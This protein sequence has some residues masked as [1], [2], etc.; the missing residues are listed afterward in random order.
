MKH[1]STIYFLVLMVNL[2]AQ[3]QDKNLL[4]RVDV[5]QLKE[6]PYSEW[7]T[8]N[9]EAYRPNA[10]FVEALKKTK[11]N[12]YTIQIFFGSWCGDSQRELPKMMRLLKEI[13]FPE[14]NVT[15]IGVDNSTDVYK[16]SPQ[17][18]ETG[19][20]IF[21][22]PTF[23]VYDGKTE[24]SR[25]VEYLAESMERDLL[26]I[27]SRQPYR[28]NYA[29]YPQVIDW[30]KEGLLLDENINARGLAMKIKESVSGDSELNACGYVLM[31]QGNVKEAVTVFKINA[32]LFPQSVNCW[33]SLGEGYAKAGLRDKAIQAYEYV[34]ELD[35]KNENARAQLL[36][37]KE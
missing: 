18:Y 15:L 16:Q 21:R 35:P 8:K 11:P 12:K 20:H 30:K 6:A 25:I 9:F 7:Y 13:G 28:S 3:H 4:D 26:K 24:V 5:A 17:R 33:D 19:K 23:I 36:K 1:Y 14:S 2:H 32:N 22:V 31:A 34:L 37:L 29:A 27:F 10:S